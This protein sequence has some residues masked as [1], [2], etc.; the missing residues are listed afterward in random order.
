MIR[1]IFENGNIASP[2][3]RHITLGAIVVNEKKQVLLVKRAQ[4]MHNGGKFTIPGGY[5]DRDENTV[6]GIL[7]ELKEE[8]GFIGEA[9]NL[10]CINDNPNRPK[11]DRQ[12]VDF[13]YIVNIVGGKPTTNIEVSD[14]S[15][16]DKNNLP[17]EDDFAFDHRNIIL[18]YFNYLEKEFPLPIVYHEF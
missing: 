5:L 16:F 10:F 3:L 18:K 9:T 11:E 1:C 6:E 14:I 7:R 12:N 4:N 15:W 8:T 13:I 2:G 17:V